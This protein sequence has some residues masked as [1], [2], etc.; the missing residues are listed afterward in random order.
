MDRFRKNLEPVGWLLDQ[1][2]NYPLLT[3]EQEILYG[4]HVQEWMSLRDI[5]EPTKREKRAIIRGR[6]AYEKFYLSNLRLAVKLVR[7]SGRK[8]GILETDDLVQEALL[9][10]SRAIQKFDPARGYKFSTY[11]YFWI[12]QGINRA[13]D[14]HQRAIR[15]PSNA[16]LITARAKKF[17]ENY[18]EIHGRDPSME[19]IAQ[20]VGAKEEILRNYFLHDKVIASLNIATKGGGHQAEESFL[21]DLVSSVDADESWN[22]AEEFHHMQDLVRHGMYGLDPDEVRVIN[23]LFGLE[24]GEG[25]ERYLMAREL[26]K[27]KGK[28]ISSEQVSKIKNRALEKMERKISRIRAQERRALQLHDAQKSSQ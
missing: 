9:G 24:T 23:H 3:P 7:Q 11:A 6:R 12:R 8:S 22:D 2:H 10:L 14:T 4:R 15:V 17:R 26:S 19:R 13:C 16:L 5:E 20:E 21:I 28:Y 18:K 1:S 25:G 27:R